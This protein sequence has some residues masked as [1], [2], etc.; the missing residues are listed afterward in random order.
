MPETSFVY[1]TN[2]QHEVAT[3]AMAVRHA[4][5][6][7][8]EGTR[9]YHV[10][11]PTGEKGKLLCGRTTA[12]PVRVEGS[13]LAP[14]PAPPKEVMYPLLAMEQ[15][16][17]GLYVTLR[18]GSKFAIAQV[19]ATDLA[20]DVVTLSCLT[21]PGRARSYQQPDPAVVVTVPRSDVLVTTVVSATAT[22]RDRFTIPV[23][24]QTRW[25]LRQR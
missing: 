6:A 14:P 11:V 12:H 16:T 5:A 9:S 25:L 21:P 8:L 1:S 15:L 18:Q 20:T 2:A 24:S 3:A 7:T 10:F 4:D 22:R 17:A 19:V 23:P 13:V